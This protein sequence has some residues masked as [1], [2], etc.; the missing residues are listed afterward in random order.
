M[1]NLPLVRILGQPWSTT[2]NFDDLNGADGLQSS[3]H[4]LNGGVEGN[5]G[6]L[7]VQL[8]IHIRQTVVVEGETEPTMSDHLPSVSSGGNQLHL[9]CVGGGDPSGVVRVLQRCPNRDSGVLCLTHKQQ[10]PET[11]A[12]PPSS[13]NAPK[14][15]RLSPRGSS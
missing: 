14:P 8:W 10:H 9:A 7:C 6:C 13:T 11:L 15:T 5:Q 12:A 2:P 4:L 3:F 1:S